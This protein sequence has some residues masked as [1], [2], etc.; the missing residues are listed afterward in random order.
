MSKSGSSIY[1]WPIRCLEDLTT[2][3]G[4][5]ATPRGGKEAYIPDGTA[6]IRSQNV[7]DN[8]LDATGIARITDDA[9][10]ALR[11]VQVQEEDVLLNITGDS[12]AR[13]CV[14][15]P[16]VLPA[17]VSQHVAIIRTTEELNPWFLQKF[18]VAPNFK[19]FMLSISSGGTRNALTKAQIGDFQI[20]LPPR[21]VQDSVA[22]VLVALDDK[23]AANDRVA[24]TALELALATY[25][26]WVSLGRLTRSEKM[27][28][29]GRWVSGGTPSTSDESY[30]G[31]DIP[32]ISAS[33]LKSPWIDSSDRR[34]TRLGAMNGTRLV[35]S[36]TIIFVVRGMSL[37]SEFRIGLTQREVAFGQD[38]KA[39]LSI[40]GID[41]AVL[42]AAIKS[43]TT[44]ILG[45]VDNAGH[46]TGR[47]GTDLLSKVILNLPG[48]EFSDAAAAVLRPLLAVGAERQ[49]ENHSLRKLRD[50]LLP[51]LMSGEVRVR[52]AEKVVEDVT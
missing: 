43:R 14:V 22:S 28:D 7:L 17:R 5:G 21:P 16:S 10:H 15:D 45:L 51:K 40:P 1:S 41:A 30:W 38:C 6:F 52:D 26:S 49:A 47:L 8:R 48:A 24:D 35:P 2:K 4:S 19:G 3:I 42:F 32:W 25:E 31:G 34:V 13:C 9:A 46:G 50:T 12:I 27:A 11:G 36:G 20:P 23:I 29:C 39:L 44:D 37:I 33:S 18:M